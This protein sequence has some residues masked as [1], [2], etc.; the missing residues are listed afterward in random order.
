[1]TSSPQFS[2]IIP[3]Y[4]RREK[5]L[6]ALES[7]N[8]QRYLNFEVLVCDD[9][10][11]D[12]TRRHVEGFRQKIRFQALYYFFAPNWGGPA[13]P[14]NI[15]LA[16]AAA[17]WICYLDSDDSWHPSKLERVLPLLHD[18]DLIYHD[19]QIISSP[20]K[21]RRHYARTLKAP[22]FEDLMIN[23][24]N[25]CIINSGVTVRKRL[26]LQVGGCTENKTFIGVEDAD[27]WLRI[28]LLTNRFTHIAEPLGTYYVD[29]GNL[30][31]YND[32]MIQQLQALFYQYVSFLKLSHQHDLAFR[33]NNYHIARICR[34]MKQDR[35]ALS[36]YWSS[37]GSPNMQILCR[38][39]FWI[40]ILNM[41]MIMGK[42]TGR[43]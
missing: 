5:L 43:R 34:L 11:G 25:G 6:R 19:F 3:T 33:T 42:L 27:L 39:L 20:Q 8:A 28:A 23:G 22:V 18:A 36:L 2:V 17:E 24:H 35:K 10:S 26:V 7:L 41:K 38:S 37:T 4:N 13:R 40:F 9:G 16:H 29:G 12:N 21:R 32:K 15:G 14:R 1:M 30:T 31:M